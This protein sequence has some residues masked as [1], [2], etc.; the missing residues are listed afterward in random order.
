[1]TV[2]TQRQMAPPRHRRSCPRPVHASSDTRYIPM[3][4]RGGPSPD[5]TPDPLGF[6]GFVLPQRQVVSHPGCPP[7]RR[8]PALGGEAIRRG[9]PRGHERWIREESEESEEFNSPMS[10]CRWLLRGFGTA[11]AARRSKNPAG[12]PFD[13]LGF[14]GLFGFFTLESLSVRQDMLVCMGV[15][16]GRGDQRRPEARPRSLVTQPQ[17]ESACPPLSTPAGFCRMNQ[18]S[19]P[20]WGMLARFSHCLLK[21]RTDTQSA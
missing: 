18:K 4:G 8:L 13:L 3:L 10:P 17:V 2:L 14:F 11:R 7:P 20:R 21:G 5:R 9:P 19:T 12:A 15:I 6:R 1:V 16:C